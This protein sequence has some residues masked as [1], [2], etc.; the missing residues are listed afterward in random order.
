MQAGDACREEKNL[1]KWGTR[2]LGHW[3]SPERKSNVMRQK[4]KN[5][6]KDSHMQDSLWLMKSRDVSAPSLTCQLLQDRQDI[7]QTL[8]FHCWKSLLLLLF[9]R[10]NINSTVFESASV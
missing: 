7:W 10:R 6:D 9:T 5:R 2:S 3:E 4:W 8:N 1:L